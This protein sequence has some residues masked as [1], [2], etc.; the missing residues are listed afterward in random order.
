[1][2]YLLIAF[3]LLAFKSNGQTPDSIYNLIIGTA[4]S[5]TITFNNKSETKYD[6]IRVVIL[7]CDTMFIP[8]NVTHV[9]AQFD[10][11]KI[12]EAKN[13]IP[14]VFWQYG[15]EVREEHCCINGNNSNYSLYQPVPYYTHKQY[16]DINKKLL[17]T[18]II[19]W[20][21]QPTK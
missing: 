3:M 10:E 4:T 17:P 1:M 11:A 6:T 13:R 16:L 15:Y 8:G 19:V 20:M 18:G 9:I 7:V 12:G 14:Y 21:S 5:G 2:K